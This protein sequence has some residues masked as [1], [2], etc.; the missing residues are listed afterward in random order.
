M[1]S[2]TIVAIATPPGVGGIAVVRL[3]GAE[4]LPIALKHLSVSALKPRYATYCTLYQEAGE[5]KKPL[6]DGIAIYYPCGYTGEPTV[7]FSCHGSRYV[8]QAVVQTF[9]DSGARLAEPGEYTMR[10]FRNGRLDLSQAE[11][12]ADLIDAVTPAQHR[13][14]VSQLRGGYANEL[15]ALRQQ[16]LDLT[17]LLELELD[18]SQEDVEFADRSKLMQLVENIS[19]RIRNLHSTFRLGNALKQGIPT[20][21]I[22]RPNAGKSSLLNAL[23]A[24]NRAIVSPIAGTTR[25]TVEETFT[26]DGITFRLIDTAGLHH[27]ADPLEQMG[28][29]RAINA[30]L[31]ADIILYVHDAT[32]PWTEVDDDMRTLRDAGVQLDEKHLWVV[33][34][35]IDLPGAVHPTDGH[36]IAISSTEGI[37]LERLRQCLVHSVDADAT[38]ANQ[39]LLSNAR[40]YE[41]LGHTDK[42]LQ[43]VALGLADGTPADL[44]AVDLRDAL[45]HLGTITGDIANDEVLTN[46][47]SRF[48]IGK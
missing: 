28:I 22:G 40:H 42:A 14:A 12:V 7:E 39:T 44:V 6:D 27:T 5:K 38:S 3:S 9:I 26:I 45:Y 43:Q 31:Q 34:N 48:C 19:L 32:R 37:G 36:S 11:A 46:I 25:D 4:A 23:L 29:D 8:Q 30:A 1:K 47:F 41:A 16:L 2:D 13:L 10:A 33:S 15:R 20:A 21:I 35:K 17:S 18:F 24:D